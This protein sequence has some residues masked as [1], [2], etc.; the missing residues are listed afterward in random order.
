[1]IEFQ[2]SFIEKRQ[3]LIILRKGLKP[4]SFYQ[5]G[6]IAEDKID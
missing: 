1:M 4:D 5:C 2:I 6:K 3:K